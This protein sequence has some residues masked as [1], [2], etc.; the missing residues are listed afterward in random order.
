VAISHRQILSFPQIS[1]IN[2]ISSSVGI[3]FALFLLL[4]E[5]NFVH[6]WYRNIV[7]TSCFDDNKKK[8]K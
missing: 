3:Y 5:T 1:W 2:L 7:L 8:K 4:L 6:I